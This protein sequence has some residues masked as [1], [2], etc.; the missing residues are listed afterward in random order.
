MRL[1]FILGLMCC[2]ASVAHAAPVTKT[3]QKAYLSLIIDDLGQN[4]PRDRRV[5][6]LPS[7]LQR[8]TVVGAVLRDGRL[9]I[10]F[11]PDPDLWG[12]L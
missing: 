5:L 11:E 6:A 2:L 4:L 9:R 7:A 3:P 1:R 10:R 8:C 12:A